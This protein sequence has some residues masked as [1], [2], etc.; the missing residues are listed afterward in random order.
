MK[1]TWK[2]PEGV[3]FERHISVDQDQ[4]FTVKEIIRNTKSKEFQAFPKGRIIRMGDMG[5]ADSKILH[6]GVVGYLGGKLQEI[7]Y[8]DIE[9]VPAFDIAS[10]GG[11][12]LFVDYF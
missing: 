9:D 3:V 1:L 4:M 7:N 10:K 8:A 5:T 2:S 12:L 11:W 6:E